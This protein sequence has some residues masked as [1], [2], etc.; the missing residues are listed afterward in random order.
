MINVSSVSVVI[1]AYHAQNTIKACIRSLEKQTD[2]PLEVVVVS[3][4]D[5]GTADLIAREFPYVR[6]FSFSSRKYPGDARNIGVRQAKGDIV[7]FIDADCTAKDDWVREIVLAHQFSEPIVGGAIANANPHSLVGWAAYF[8]EFSQWMPTGDARYMPDVPTISLSFKRW[9][10]EK[11]GPFL[12]GMYCSDTAFNWRAGLDGYM[13]LFRPSIQVSHVNI[14][15]LRQFLPKQVMHG[16]SFAMMRIKERRLSV[17]RIGAL[18]LGSPLL[19]F[20]LFFR[21]LRRVLRNSHYFRPFSIASPLVLLGLAAWSWGECTGY[22]T[23]L[24]TFARSERFP[25]SMEPSA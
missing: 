5:D 23:G 13:T 14:T 4:G 9:A 20:L 12:E 16:N 8:C 15:K 24:W 22:W 18:A 11:Y 6:L 3:S 10:F 25:E 21:I 7:A 2:R 19:P 1:A 17:W